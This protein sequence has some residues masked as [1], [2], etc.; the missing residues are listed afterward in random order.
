MGSLG[1][2]GELLWG[3]HVPRAC[4]AD[5]S[6]EC[7]GGIS[8]GCHGGMSQRYHGGI[9]QGCHGGTSQRCHGGMSEGCCGFVSQRG[10]LV[11]SPQV[12]HVGMSQRGTQRGWRCRAAIDGISVAFF[13]ILKNLLCYLNVPLQR[14]KR[15]R[16]SCILQAHG[17]CMGNKLSYEMPELAAAT[18]GEISFIL[19]YLGVE[20][21]SERFL[22]GVRGPAVELQRESSLAVLSSP[23]IEPV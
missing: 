13:V 21:K 14:K 12:C 10:A 22:G 20:I 9:Y 8:E 2:P 6:Q 5:M 15:G 16:S 3:G 17:A 1:S 23:L 4:H 7:R 11:A 18:G 19:R